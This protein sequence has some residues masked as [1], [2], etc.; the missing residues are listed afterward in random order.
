MLNIFNVINHIPDR[1]P[2]QDQEGDETQKEV[3]A[4]RGSKGETVVT[5]KTVPRIPHDFEQS[6]FFDHRWKFFSDASQGFLQTKRTPDFS[7]KRAER[8]KLN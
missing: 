1:S 6:V 7:E 2:E 8:Q 5:V 4:Y 3:E